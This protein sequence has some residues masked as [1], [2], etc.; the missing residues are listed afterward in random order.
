MRMRISVIVPTLNPGRHWGAFTTA[1]LEN[2]RDLGLEPGSVLVLDSASSDGTAAAA[3]AAGFRVRPV[4]RTDFDHGGTR[5]LAVECETASHVLVFLT[6]DALLARADSI[7]TLLAAF[8][9]EAIG[10]AYGRQLPRQGARGIEVHARLFNYPTASKVR[11][12]E[13]RE[14]LGFKSIF[15]SNSFCAFRREALIAVG[16]FPRRAI[17]SEET[18]AIGHMHLAGWKSAYV[19][20]AAVY[21][22]HPY[23]M[24]EEF[25]R[26]FDVG[27]TH[28]R[29]SFLVE[30]F[31]DAHGEGKR[32]V[33]SEL[34]YL[35][36][37]NPLQ[38]PAAL[39]RTLTKFAGY[40][41]GR[42]ENTLSLANRRRLSMNSSFWNAEARLAQ[43]Q[44]PAR[45][46]H[47]AARRQQGIARGSS[48]APAMVPKQLQAQ[49]KLRPA[50]Q[51]AAEVARV[52]SIQQQRL[53]K[54]H[55]A[56]SRPIVDRADPHVM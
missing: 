10:A 1:L 4:A 41:L 18:I 31:G 44:M 21:H 29:E 24:V 47:A 13:D 33:K 2:L 52:P 19:A 27:V 15:S 9:D 20:E 28:A 46:S 32:F 17:C 6:Q 51:L 37:H 34:R 36:R 3:Q 56:A 42:R 55:Q 45:P 25:Q 50:A 38:I 12:L 5:Q 48:Q 40:R 53:R 26:Y 14:A 54:I 35:L 11:S 49:A 43:Q 22:S 7:R 39:L 23:T 30:V 8:D 16:G